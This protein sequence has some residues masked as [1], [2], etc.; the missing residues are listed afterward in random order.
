MWYLYV[1]TFL[2]ALLLTYLV[3]ILALKKSIM[4]VPN[5][6]SSHIVPTP[7]GGGIALGIAWYI[8]LSIA[9]FLNE[10]DLNFF[11]ALLSGLIIVIVGLIDDIKDL[12]PKIRIIAQ[13]FAAGLALFF[14]GG[15]STVDLGF[16][17]IE[18]I[19]VLTPLAFIGIIWFINLFNF[20]DG[21]DGYIGTGTFIIFVSLFAF[22]NDNTALVFAVAAIGFLFWNWQPAKIFMGDVGS[23][24]IGFNV[25]VYAIYYQNSDKVS[26]ISMLILS[27]IFWFDATLTLLRRW[28]NKEKLSEAHKKHAY[29]RLVQSGFSHQKTVLFALCLNIINIILFYL[30][31]KYDEYLLILFFCSIILSYLYVKYA[32]IRKPFS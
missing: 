19:Y 8:G 21:I 11:L 17:K 6:R 20:S 5:D 30:A 18:N 29:Q 1:L 15:L 28:K 13:S 31:F 7:R 16:F 25:A 24:L 2:S 9:F 22:Y 32:D 27:S 4:D 26:L 12:N 3:R 10:I 23:T 14:L